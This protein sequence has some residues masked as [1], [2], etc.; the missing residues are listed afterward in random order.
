M[1]YESVDWIH[2]DDIDQLQPVWCCSAVLFTGQ[3]ECFVEQSDC[4]FVK[5][6]LWR[7]VESSTEMKGP[8][9]GCGEQYRNERSCEGMWRAVQKWKVLW[10]NVESSTEM[11]GPV[12]GCGEQYRNERSCEGMWRAVQKW[13]VLWM[14]NF[15][16]YFRF[17]LSSLH[18][19]FGLCSRPLCPLI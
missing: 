7:D 4:Y 6:Q 2:V 12:K 10:R 9:K 3:F 16:V 11:K 8:V 1:R 14:K 17:K 18:M 13:K 19:H 15:W 5:Q